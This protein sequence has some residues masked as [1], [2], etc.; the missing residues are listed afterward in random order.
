MSLLDK[1]I[2]FLNIPVHSLT[3]QETLAVIDEYISSGRQ[4]HHVVI[5]AGKVVSMQKDPL[6][7]KNV[8]SSDL[9]NADGQAIVWAS[10]FLG[11]PLP[12]RVTGIDLMMNL[13]ELAYRKKYKCFFFGAREEIVRTVIEKV[14]AQYS[15]EIIAGYRNGY[16]D[17]KD[18]SLIADQ[19]A[20]SGAQMLFVAITSPKKE[21]FLAKYQANLEKVNL[22]MGVGG[23]FDVLAGLTKRAPVWMQNAGLEW[24]YRL[25]Q[26]PGRMWKRYLIG[27]LSFIRLVLKMKFR[28]KIS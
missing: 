14:S 26:E 28:K 17:E 12:E 25:V 27:N 9:I 1:K 18:E 10:R 19:I 5:N 4:L 2:L 13:L 7:Y 6:L 23:S 20:E 11:L 3:M 22:I 16:F 24:F 8:V 15:P 21:N